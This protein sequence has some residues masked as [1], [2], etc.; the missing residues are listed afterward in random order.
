M[1][2][3]SKIL[4]I[5][6]SIT[7]IFSVVLVPSASA[8]GEAYLTDLVFDGYTVP[9]FNA[10]TPNYTGLTL[11][12][13]DG[14]TTPE[15]TATVAEGCTYDVETTAD[16]V[17]VTVKKDGETVKTYTLTYKVIG[18]NLVMNPGF[19]N[20]SDHNAGWMRANGS[21]V[22][23][24]DSGAHS[25][26][27][28]ML[29]SEANSMYYQDVEVPEKWYCLTAGWA[30]GAYGATGEDIPSFYMGGLRMTQIGEQNVVKATDV[31]QTYVHPIQAWE[32][33]NFLD[34]TPISTLRVRV[35][36]DSTGTAYFDD[37]YAGV[38]VAGDLQIT[39]PETITSAGITDL[40]AQVVNQLRTTDGIK[41]QPSVSWRVVEAPA[42]V[43]INA[44]T[45]E[46]TIPE[47][48]VGDIIVEATAAPNWGPAEQQAAQTIIG[49]RVEIEAKVAPAEVTFS[50]NGNN[51]TPTVKWFNDSLVSKIVRVYTAIFV[52][53]DGAEILDDVVISDEVTVES[54]AI[55][56]A[57]LDPVT[58]PDSCTVK[59][60]VLTD[61]LA[62]VME[63]AFYN[64]NK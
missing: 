24:Y 63:N 40:N 53:V 10:N 3:I 18:E 22:R 61:C 51:V 1:K 26:S 28:S 6:L 38:L 36:S 13:R 31:G 39:A 30:R 20:E 27:Y 17:T 21:V 48:C 62:P 43:S 57:E 44:S 34:K 33:I 64:H 56:E 11:P 4:S 7:L 14:V 58:V 59:S 50:A 9:G 32:M 29:S 12:W 8:E 45:G 49:N 25:G 41:V 46:L 47:V 55:Y 2:K 42:G 15:V 54:G 16:T 52:N 19:E 23:A 37:F 35:A 60:F 5:I